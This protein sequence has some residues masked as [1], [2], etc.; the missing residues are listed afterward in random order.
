M[1]YSLYLFSKNLA[2]DKTSFY[3]VV[4]KG[5]QSTLDYKISKIEYYFQKL[6]KKCY[7]HLKFHVLII[8]G[9]DLFFNGKFVSP[10]FLL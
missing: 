1:V 9:T 2:G 7:I 5:A 3:L 6:E 4:E 10:F 8:L